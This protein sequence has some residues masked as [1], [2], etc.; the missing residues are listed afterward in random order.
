MS[1]VDVQESIRDRLVVEG[2]T[3]EREFAIASLVRPCVRLS[4]TPIPDRQILLGATKL[5]GDPDLPL[6]AEWPEDDGVRMNFIAQLDLAE[7]SR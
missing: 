5:G 2:W 3:S 6:G 4:T 1:L 7:I